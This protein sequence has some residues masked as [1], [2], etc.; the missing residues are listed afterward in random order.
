MIRRVRR[1]E[2]DELAARFRFT[3]DEAEADQL[4]VLTEW[5]ADAFDGLDAIPPP[6][7][8][9]IVAERH[10][11]ARP[12]EGEDP[13]NAI[14]RWCRVKADADGDLSGTRV[15]IKDSV[16]IAG[17]PMT[18]GSKVLQSFVPTRDSV[19]TERL[20]RA[21]AEIVAT[22]NMDYLA[23]SGGGDTSA[24]GYTRNPF[25]T[26]RTAGGSSS[27]SG[28]ALH[29][30]DIDVTI[31]CDQGGS[32][33]V[34]AAWC[35]VVGLKP[36][37]TL[38]PYT[39]IAGIDATYD[40]CGPMARTVADTARLL[41]V[42]AGAHDSDPRQ[43]GG[44]TAGDYVKAV[45]EAP[46][47]LK[48][49]TIGVV[50]E[51]WV[52]PL[53][54]K[55]ETGDVVREAVE[56]LASLGAEV[57]EVSVAEHYVG[58]TVAIGCFIEGMATLIASGGN[59]YHH[60]GEYWPELALAFGSG[61]AGYGD[62]LSPQIKLALIFGGHLQQQ[63]RGALYGRA[64]N[65]RPA[66]RAGYDRALAECDF[67]VMPTTPGPPHE[68]APEMPI[69][70]HVTRGWGMLSNT[71]PTDMSGHP[72]IT[73]PAGEYEG[74]PAG[75]MAIGRQFDDAGLLRLARTYEQNFDWAPVHAGDP[76]RG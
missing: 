55:A 6:E 3:L 56:R 48:G 27:G 8:D 53:G 58:G 32:I 46:D 41:Q 21:G 31:G 5:L 17:I 2:L 71:S 64:Q 16:A 24:Y 30:D 15:A 54:E 52:D 1:T 28:A 69:S 36:T 43:A 39:G 51:G 4:H 14:V 40:H 57:R 47:D 65:L 9:V 74:L 7:V 44:V 18:C 61:L 67:L 37:H 62:E 22:T 34:P 60:M 10:V 50:A 29:Y 19:V 70:E 33:R 26:D 20:L 72:A 75:L 13:Y 38:V 59:S 12:A 45:G 49:V 68:F 73:I 76:R 25:D 23:F 35:G 63:Y 66:L 11:G 42:I